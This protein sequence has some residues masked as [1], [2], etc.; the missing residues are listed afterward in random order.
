MKDQ[1]T[2]KTVDSSYFE[3]PSIIA[4]SI[5]NPTSEKIQQILDSY[6]KSN[7]YLIGCFLGEKLMGIV[8]FKVHNNEITIRHISVLAEFQRKGIG[9]MLINYVKDHF[10]PHIILAETDEDSLN[11]YIKLGFKY[12]EIQNQHSRIRYKCKLVLFE[13]RN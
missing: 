11:F 3:L 10:K 2:L 9:A 6:K 1:I 4:F 13:K 5:G 8:G 7:Q 12:R